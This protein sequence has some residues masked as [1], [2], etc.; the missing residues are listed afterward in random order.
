MLGA[1]AVPVPEVVLSLANGDRTSLTWQNEV[2][3]LT[4]EVGAGDRRRFVK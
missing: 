2:G 4:Y 1:M 3:G